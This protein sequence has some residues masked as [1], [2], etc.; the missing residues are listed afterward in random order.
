MK[1]LGVPLIIL[2]GLLWGSMGVLLKL[3]QSFG[4]S[5]I[6]CTALRLGSAALILWI[7]VGI[8]SPKSLKISLKDLPM[9]LL[10]GAISVG[11]MSALYLSAIDL[12]SVSVA[13]VLLYTSPVWVMIFSVLFLK[14][15]LTVK[16][17]VAAIIAFLG[18]ACIA[19]LGGDEKNSFI[20]ILIGVLSGIFYASYSIFGTFALK[21]NSGITVTCYAFLFAAIVSF[22]IGDLSGI[23]NV[24][25]TSEQVP[26]LLGSVFLLGFIT[27]VAPFALYTIG[28]K[29]VNA[30]KAAVLVC[31]EPITA[32]F[33][34]FFLYGEP[35]NYL[36]I[37]LILVA[38]LMLAKK[39]TE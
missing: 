12:T 13:A 7:S 27:A 2:A 34:G 20:G 18:C 17:A 9:L 31:V 21:K 28:L 15:K 25:A 8:F 6:N 39:D 11:G 3:T 32:A 19:G 37:G 14:E 24:I 29:H 22:C 30:S 26:A 16:K 1:K 5:A 4:F 23:A 10:C 36:G 35:L 33:F 38:I